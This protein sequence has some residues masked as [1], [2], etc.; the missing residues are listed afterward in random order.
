MNVATDD[1]RALLMRV[2]RVER[3]FRWLTALAIVLALLCVALLAWQFA[4]LDSIVEARG[5]VLR[6]A[7][8]QPRAELRVHKDGAPYF[9]LNNH[10]GRPGAALSVRDDGA[11]SLR[12]LDN[13][14]QERIELKLDDNGVP[15][16]T[17]KGSNGRARIALTAEETGE[18]GEQRIVL[19]DRL[20]RVVW[21]APP[22]A[23]A[24]P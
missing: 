14:E 23:R 19:R 24:T 21:S 16:V 10:A 5:F 13:A 15:V 11:V 6:D 18:G 1:G 12:L 2:E 4:P 3:K 17:L 20:G 7:N 22:E 9:R 8:W